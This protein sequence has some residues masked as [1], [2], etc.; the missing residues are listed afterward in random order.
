MDYKYYLEQGWFIGSGAIES[1]HRNVVQH[2]MKLNGQRWGSKAQPILNLRA[3]NKS[4]KWDKVVQLIE[5]K[6]FKKAA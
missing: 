3:A 6:S 2:R 5:D 4:D 1:A